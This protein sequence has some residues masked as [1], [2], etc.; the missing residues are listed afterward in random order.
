MRGK[1]ILVGVLGMCLLGSLG[2]QAQ[3]ADPGASD[4]TSAPAAAP[5]ASGTIPRLIKFSGTVK[6]PAGQPATGVVGL[7]FSLY[8][9]PEGGT[10]LWTESQS[11]ALDAQGHYTALLGA[12]SP[13]GLPLGLFTSGQALWVGVQPQLPGEGDQQRVLL[14]AAPD[15]LKSSDAGTLGG[16]PASA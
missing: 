13:G 2:L 16:L 12:E 1:N 7:T 8:E 14:V 4:S 11:L 6:D 9:L 10:P 5:S 3:Q 15:A